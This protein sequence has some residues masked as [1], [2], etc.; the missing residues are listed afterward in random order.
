MSC[1]ATDVST[2][3]NPLGESSRAARINATTATPI[4]THRPAV[5]R[6]TV[7]ARGQRA[8]SFLLERPA[9]SRR[10]VGAHPRSVR[11]E[12]PT[13]GSTAVFRRYAAGATQQAGGQPRGRTR[14]GHARSRSVHV[15]GEGTDDPQVP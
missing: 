8:P 13:G 15:G 7:I 10:P 12:V 3:W 2:C 11:P 6:F 5:Q 4:Q 9:T 14:I 1:S